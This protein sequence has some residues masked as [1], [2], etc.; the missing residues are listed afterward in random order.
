MN[1]EL[2]RQLL[3][4]DTW[5]VLRL[6][7]QVAFFVAVFYLLNIMYAFRDV[8]QLRHLARP[9]GTFRIPILLISILF[10][11]LLIHQASWQLTGVFRPRFIGFM[12]LHDRREFN[13]VHWIQ[14]GRILDRRG[15]VLAESRE[16]QGKVRRVYPDGPVFAPVVGYCHPRFGTA[17][18]EAVATV[19]L[20]GGAP[21]KLT[22]WGELGRQLV[23]Q[24]KR[25]YGQDLQLTLDADLQRFAVARLGARH[26]AAVL[27]R[28]RDGAL[29]VLASV[30]SYDPNRIAAALFQSGEA[31]G[32]LLNRATQ[33]L[34]PPGSAFKIALAG[35]ALER[36]FT[37]TFDCPADGFT[38]SARY[39]K[40]RDHEYYEALE[41]GKVWRGAGRL[42]LN[43]ALTRSS[44]VF[45]AQLGVRYGPRAFANLT[46]R[47]YLNRQ[48]P[49]HASAHGVWNMRTGVVPRLTAGDR[50]GLAQ[51]SIG[52]GRLLV[53]PAYL[54][55]LASAVANRGLAMTP[56]LIER[57]PPVPLARFMSADTAERLV[58]ML[59][60][61]VT[62]GTGRGIDNPTLAIAGKTGT[63][64]NP[65]GDAHSWFVGFAPAQR[66]VLAIAVL[67]EHGGFGS[68]VA[69][70]LARDLLLRAQARGLLRN[71][72]GQKSPTRKA[73]S[74]HF[75]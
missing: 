43:Q 53:T 40:I 49:L 44:N 47:L 9:K 32:L 37:G 19:H 24:D 17:G 18:L 20:N 30:P 2:L 58:P 15:E 70:P 31:S 34:Y 52:Q 54:A 29:H 42:D 1:R 56:R 4:P 63:A 13:P 72:N 7:L 55:L 36:G 65:H 41:K 74:E 23:T 28:V 3:E 50:Y 16:I 12:Q 71:P 11:A 68:A 33:G 62:E 21:T 64:Q 57:A 60:R 25:T 69:A 14:R 5:A 75:R 8:T 61:V 39:R 67:V 22:D 51:M 6:A 45:F 73:Q 59:R 10:I 48:I 66:P 27:M 26:G 46:D 38:T 35:L